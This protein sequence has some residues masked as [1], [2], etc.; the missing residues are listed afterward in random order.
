MVAFA[1]F[2]H[3]L[4]GTK[5]SLMNLLTNVLLHGSRYC[6]QGHPLMYVLKI[7]CS[8]LDFYFGF[9]FL[10]KHEE[11]RKIAVKYGHSSTQ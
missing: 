10:K 7:T 6:T 9:S 1:G 3:C 11:G 2:A 8:M 4:L 5:S